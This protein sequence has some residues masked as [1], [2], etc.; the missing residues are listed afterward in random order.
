MSLFMGSGLADNLIR[1]I[2]RLNEPIDMCLL[3]RSTASSIARR[4][5]SQPT[6]ARRGVP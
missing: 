1:S 5:E 2:L 3:H 4:P 6:T